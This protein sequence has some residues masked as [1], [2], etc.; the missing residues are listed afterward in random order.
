MIFKVLL[1]V[2]VLTLF[3]PLSCLAQYQTIKPSNFNGGGY[4]VNTYDASGRETGYGTLRKS[5]SGGYRGN[6]NYHNRPS[7]T[8]DE[9]QVYN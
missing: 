1:P 8:Q 7:M 9:F 6:I 4:R 3:S 5:A 2:A